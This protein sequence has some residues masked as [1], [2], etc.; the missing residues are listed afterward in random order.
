MYEDLIAWKKSYEFTLAVY[1]ATKNFPREEVYG[2]IAQMRRAASSIPANI[3]EGSMR[4][5]SKE[6]QHFLR[7][8]RGSMAEM[9]VWI[10]LAYDLEYIDKNAYERLSSDC[11]EIGRLLSGLLK[12]I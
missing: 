7:I 2:L 4:Q 5:S 12:S 9:E 1:K 3:A 10:R 6:F 8:A 11:D